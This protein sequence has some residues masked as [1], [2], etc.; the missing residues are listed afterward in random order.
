MYNSIEW[1]QFAASSP[2]KEAAHWTDTTF[3]GI[4][5][6]WA[7]FVHSFSYSRSIYKQI[8]T[9][10]I[11]GSQVRWYTPLIPALKKLRCIFQYI[12]INSKK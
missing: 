3:P 2:Q 12:L 10:K 7:L 8:H 6:S 9:Q 11:N 1:G 5:T 4:C